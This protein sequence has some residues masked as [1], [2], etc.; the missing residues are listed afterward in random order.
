MIRECHICGERLLVP[1]LGTCPNCR[2]TVLPARYPFEGSATLSGEFGGPELG[3]RY[4]PNCYVCRWPPG[5]SHALFN[6][7]NAHFAKIDRDLNRRVQ[8]TAKDAWREKEYIRLLTCPRCHYLFTSAGESAYRS[9]AGGMD[10]EQGRAE[11]EHFMTYDKRYLRRISIQ[12]GLLEKDE[13]KKAKA[14]ARE[15]RK[16]DGVSRWD[17]I[18]FVK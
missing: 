5:F 3:E 14:K 4:K 2:K 15:K 16:R 13:K 8:P 6:R 12:K 11:L 10:H 1:D 9:G 7:A 17:W 18:P